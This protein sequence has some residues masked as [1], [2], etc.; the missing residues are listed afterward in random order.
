MT[1][2][3]ADAESIFTGALEK[4]TTAERAAY[5]DGACGS[6]AELRHRVEAL[7]VA[8]DGAASFLEEPAMGATIETFAASEQLGTRIGPYKLLQLIGEGGFG[9]VY[10]AEQ[11]EP[12][13]RKV[14]LKVIK[15]GM[16]TRQVIARFE[17]ERQ[18]LAMMDH[19]HIARVL[20]A[21]ATDAGR[22]YFVMELVKG[23]PITEYCDKNNLDTDARLDLF[24]NVCHAVQHAH[25]K[26][27]IHRDIKPTNVMVT[28]HD[29][30]PV[31][32]LVDFGIAK[33]T[34]QR[35]TEKTLFT[36]FRQFVGTPEYMSP[37]QAEMSGLDIDT[38]TDIYSLG[39]L[40]YEL[41]TGTTP[42][43]SKTLREAGYGEIQRIIREREPDRPSTRLSTMGDEVSD[44]A[45]HR[46]T[47]PGGLRKLLKGDLDWIVM[48]A[49]EKDRTRR[50]ETANGMA[51]D[52]TRY[53]VCEPV[54]ATPP[55]AAYRL[56]KFVRRNRG[57]VTGGGVI[58][59]A[60]L[61]GLA[62]AS[63]GFV[64][65]KRQEAVAV[66]EA[67]NAAALSGFLQEMLSSV[68]PSEAKGKE[69]TLVTM[70]EGAGAKLDD[71]TLD[72]NPVA[73]AAIRQTIGSTYWSLG[74]AQAAIPHAERV[75]ELRRE[76][77]GL[78]HDDTL[79]AM[80]WLGSMYRRV[81]NHR[82]AEPML[83][84]VFET[85]KRIRGDRHEDTLDAMY[86]HAWNQFDVGR[87]EE[88][89]RIHKACLALR[90]DALGENH[91]TTLGSWNCT[92]LTHVFRNQW[93]EAEP[94]ITEAYTRGRAIDSDSTWTLLFASNLGEIYFNLER[95]EE[96]VELLEENAQISRRV[97]G[98]TSGRT[99]DLIDNLLRAYG[100][101]GRLEDAR[102][103]AIE[104]INSN[105]R[106]VEESPSDPR[107]HNNY[108]WSLLTCEPEDLRD[109][110]TALAVALKSNELT[111]FQSPDYLDTLAT[112]YFQ[113]GDVDKAI[114][115]Q[116]AAIELLTPG[117]HVRHEMEQRLAE[118]Q[119]AVP[120]G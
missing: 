101:L 60:V 88:G 10:M 48:K 46:H 30:K 41:L 54:L 59:A 105:K 51:M 119:A 94:F 75:V 120:T 61:L 57:A 79:H 118:F 104:M 28:L 23:I 19:P 50:Y 71:H 66:K 63:V 95:Y 29:G 84:Q 33:A 20:D 92:G 53:Q 82:D 34:N 4:A 49:I 72:D 107:V 14:A 6:D 7:L 97:T 64:Q 73:E 15:L 26:G 65:A 5:L 42:F 58:A 87:P 39:V 22:P 17:A 55:S 83:T 85:L 77:L 111:N 9:V 69:F 37:E 102:P 109:P 38:R 100:A 18:A 78:D 89:E 74:L 31:P 62:A 114:D 90:R 16:D 68:A 21:G 40:L 44:V 112:A 1:I 108:A 45:K 67:Q 110:S 25:Q 52:V 35:L 43:D 12:V 3:T 103:W 56:R 8:H 70:L 99:I 113:T 86:W 81:D 80:S 24:V 36:E 116:R 98:P 11:E 96:A 93:E 2:K 13:R 117:D 115:T 32:K 27:I 47:D 76:H 106:L 91:W